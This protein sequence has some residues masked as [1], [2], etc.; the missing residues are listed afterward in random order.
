MPYKVE[1]SDVYTKASGK[2]RLK[3]H[4]QS[5]AKAES[6]VRLLRGIE[7]GTIKLGRG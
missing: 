1:D 5:K 6:A 4:C 3:Q 7:K 2:W